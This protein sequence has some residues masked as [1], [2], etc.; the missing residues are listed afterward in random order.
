[1]MD[2]QAVLDGRNRY[3]KLAHIMSLSI[4]RNQSMYR[5]AFTGIRIL[6]EVEAYSQCYMSYI[7]LSQR[8]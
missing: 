5:K 4:L 7:E 8:Q 3:G 1:M 6:M 2:G